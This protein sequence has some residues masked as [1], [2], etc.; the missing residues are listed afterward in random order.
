MAAETG[1]DEELFAVVGFGE[2]EHEDA[3]G[4]VVEVG[5][6]EAGQGGG[7]FVG[8]NVHVEGGEAL[9]HRC[10]P[11]HTRIA[12]SRT[13]VGL[14]VGLTDM[15]IEMF[16]SRR[17]HPL[18]GGARLPSV[19]YPSRAHSAS[20]LWGRHTNR[21]WE[22]LCSRSRKVHQESPMGERD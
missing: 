3:G 1:V 22:W 19:L 17:H 13:V 18:F 14:R 6:A 7:E 9:L 4:E 20:G 2:F 8:D 21:S 12:C 11:V 5:E 10:G 15:E 16:P